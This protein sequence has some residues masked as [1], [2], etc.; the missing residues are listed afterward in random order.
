MSG[1]DLQTNWT[2]L[3]GAEIYEAQNAIVFD[4]VE[5]GQFAEVFVKG[6]QHASFFR[7]LGEDGIVSRVFAPITAPDDIVSGCLQLLGCQPGDTRIQQ[8]F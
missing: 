3:A 7:R 1:Q 2:L 4:T 5:H 6:D 8:D